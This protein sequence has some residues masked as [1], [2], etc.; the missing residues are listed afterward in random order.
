MYATPLKLYPWAVLDVDAL[1]LGIH[2]QLLWG[3]WGFHDFEI[4]YDV[5]NAT[6]EL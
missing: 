6:F 1:F 4:L 5:S 2:F 3:S